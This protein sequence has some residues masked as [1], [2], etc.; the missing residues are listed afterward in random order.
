MVIPEYL[1]EDQYSNVLPS[2][3][4]LEQLNVRKR[5][6]ERWKDGKME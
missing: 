1:V 6:M 2:Q 3:V 5:K 4:A